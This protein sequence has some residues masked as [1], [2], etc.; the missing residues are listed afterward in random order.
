MRFLNAFLWLFVALFCPFC[1][2]TVGLPLGM[3]KKLKN[4]A[5]K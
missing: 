5:E 2:H 3:G 1:E 4:Y